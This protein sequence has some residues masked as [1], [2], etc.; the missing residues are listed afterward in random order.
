M[1]AFTGPQG[2]GALRTH[3]ETKRA[4]AQAR[5]A[6]TKPERRKAARRGCPTGK[7]RFVTEQYARAELVGTA[8]ARNTGRNQRQ[9]CR[10]YQC[11][12]CG[13]WHLTSKP[14]RRTT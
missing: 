5:N 14:E 6:T 11:P 9:E 2:P 13:G 8:I 10:C 12:M 7:R 3:R 1:S 4:E